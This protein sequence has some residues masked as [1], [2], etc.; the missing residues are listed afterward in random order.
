MPLS[1][2]QQRHW[3]LAD[4]DDLP[5]EAVWCEVVDGNLVV[6]P[7]P[8]QVHQDIGAELAIALRDAAPPGWRVRVEYLLPLAEDHVRVPDLVV[9]RWPLR[10]PRDDPS[11][12]MGPADVG[13]VAE[14]VSPRSRRT[15]R[16]AK[17]AEYADAGIGIYWRIE[18]DPEVRLH[19]F[20]LRGSVYEPA[21]AGQDAPVPWG[22]MPITL[23]G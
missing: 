7:P 11:N 16:F 18:T 6:S 14:V 4:W 9:Y 20:V 15:D 5:E 17:P 12:P 1:T 21:P 23:G 10:H 19:A 8:P 13:L 2:P 3:T 22:R